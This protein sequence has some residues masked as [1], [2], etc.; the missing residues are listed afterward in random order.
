[1]LVDEIGDLFALMKQTGS[2]LG[3]IANI[4]PTLKA[5]YSASGDPAWTGDALAN[6]DHQG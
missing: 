6:L 3:A 4:E 2:K 5:L 1:M